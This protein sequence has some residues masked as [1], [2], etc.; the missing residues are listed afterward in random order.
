MGFWSVLGTAFIWSRLDAA[1]LAMDG[2]GS[3]RE[4]VLAAP[5]LR[6]G[7]GVPIP[8]TDPQVSTVWLEAL[9][10][11][12]SRMFQMPPTPPPPCPRCPHEHRWTKTQAAESFIH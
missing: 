6:E 2:Y 5:D 9:G 3:T 1:L 4:A 11:L 12:P 10:A 7:F 8:A